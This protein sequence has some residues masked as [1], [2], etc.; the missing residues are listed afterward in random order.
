MRRGLILAVLSIGF[1][2]CSIEL[3]AP[4]GPQARDT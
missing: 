1:V 3:P 2:A 4:T